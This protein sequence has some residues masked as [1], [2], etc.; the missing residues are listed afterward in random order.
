MLGDLR[1]RRRSADVRHFRARENLVTGH[2]RA[3]GNLV[4]AFAGATIS[5]A[6][7]PVRAFQMMF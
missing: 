7:P 2:S 6:L 1:R 3:S 4:P 5:E